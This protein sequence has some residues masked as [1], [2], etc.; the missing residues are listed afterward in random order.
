MWFLLFLNLFLDT[1][2]DAKTY[3]KHPQHALQ[4]G[5][6]SSSNIFDPPFGSV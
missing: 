6:E 1:S 3:P 4:Q 5:Q 2:D